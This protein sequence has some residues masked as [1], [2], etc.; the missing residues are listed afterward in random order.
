M[1]TIEEDKSGSTPCNMAYKWVNVSK[2][3]SQMI[4]VLIWIMND[5]IYESL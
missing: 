2:N 1:I 5:P 4:H 3:M